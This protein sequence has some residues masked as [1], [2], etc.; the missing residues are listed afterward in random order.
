MLMY[1]DREDLNASQMI[2]HNSKIERKDSTLIPTG[3]YDQNVHTLSLT[4]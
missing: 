2:S 4:A 3:Y 1:T